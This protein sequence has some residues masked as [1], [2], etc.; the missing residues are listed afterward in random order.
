MTQAREIRIIVLAGLC[1][2]IACV[3]LHAETED[4]RIFTFDEMPHLGHDLE[5]SFVAR[6]GDERL[7]FG[8]GE[9]GGRSRQG[10]IPLFGLC[11]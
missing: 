11:S 2:L 9:V 4:S 6:A 8:G 7:V 5:Q 10:D 1:L 3:S